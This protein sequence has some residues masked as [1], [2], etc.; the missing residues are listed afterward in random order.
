MYL[1]GAALLFAIGQVFNYVISTHICQATNG[2]IDGS[3]FETLF[4]LLAVVALWVFWSSI[5]EDEWPS[6]VVASSYPYTKATRA[7]AVIRGDPYSETTRAPAASGPDYDPYAE[8]SRAPG[9]SYDPYAEG[10]RA[11]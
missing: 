3:L 5:T 11:T 10:A 6:P 1:G 2:K 7:S 9:P 4:T 8:T